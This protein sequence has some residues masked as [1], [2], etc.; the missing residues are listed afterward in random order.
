VTSKDAELQAVIADEAEHA[1][2]T[3]GDPVP[4]EALARATRPNRTKSVMFSL[5][6]NPDE[7]AEL[8]SLAEARTV[9]ASTLVRGWIM[10]RLIAERGTP[11][12]AA[13]MLDRLENDVHLLRKLVNAAA[14]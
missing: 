6:L 5:R 11:S 8:Q 1:E 4:A 9:P 12:D 7:L 14:G 10:Q 2:A 3:R 13:T